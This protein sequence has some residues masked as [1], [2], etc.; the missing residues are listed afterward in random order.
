M[1][2]DDVVYDLEDDIVWPGYLGSSRSRIEKRVN[3]E[4]M[5]RAILGSKRHTETV[6]NLALYLVYGAGK[7]RG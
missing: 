4:I 2:P 3:I 6:N 1:I 7:I 5:L